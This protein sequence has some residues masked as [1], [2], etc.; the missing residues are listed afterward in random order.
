MGA[1]PCDELLLAGGFNQGSAA[2]SDGAVESHTSGG[3][4]GTGGHGLRMC[5]SVHGNLCI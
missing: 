4:H 2:L 1:R 3:R 5:P